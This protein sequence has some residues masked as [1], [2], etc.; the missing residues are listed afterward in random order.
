MLN[1]HT[2]GLEMSRF[3]RFLQVNVRVYAYVKD[4]TNITETETLIEWKFKSMT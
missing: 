1:C 2:D 4:L 3:T